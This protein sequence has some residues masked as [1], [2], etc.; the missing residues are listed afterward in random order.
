MVEGEGF[1]PSKAEPADLQSA[2]FDRS[3]TPPTKREI[4][5]AGRSAR[6]TGCHAAQHFRRTPR[7]KAFNSITCPQCGA[8]PGDA[9][10]PLPLAANPRGKSCLPL[11]EASAARVFGKFVSFEPARRRRHRAV[12]AGSPARHLAVI[13][14]SS[15]A[16]TMRALHDGS[17][18]C[19]CFFRWIQSFAR[20]LARTACTSHS[21]ERR[22]TSTPR[23]GCATACSPARWARALQAGGRAR[24]GRVRRLVRA[25]D[26]ARRPLRRGRRH[27]P[28]PHG[29]SRRAAGLVLRRHRVRPLAPRAAAAGHVR[30][31][32]RLHPPGLPQRRGDHAA[33]AGARGA[34]AASA[35]AVT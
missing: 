4:V 18:A 9:C 23:N 5:A 29:G 14:A 6:Q 15:S 35:A 19:R 17:R 13:A 20:R 12:A 26:R 22:A 28:G 8:A 2:P 7:D 25:P 3:G 32:P 31:R 33:V 11:G 21:P 24:R 30:G 1:E 16:D 10:R 27:L 34:H